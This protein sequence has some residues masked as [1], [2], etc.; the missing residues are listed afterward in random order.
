MLRPV[1]LLGNGLRC[2]PALVDQLCQ[3]NVPVLTTWQGADLVPEDSPVFCGRPGVL[4]Q[5][6]A[7]I[8]QQKSDVLMCIGARLDMEQLGHNPEGFA[9]HA[10]KVVID[11]DDAELRKFPASW[12]R[13]RIDL[14][15]PLDNRYGQ[16]LLPLISG[17]QEWLDWCKAL[18]RRFRY[19]LEGSESANYVDP[20]Y[21]VSKL[22]EAC[23]PDAIIV[24][25]SSGLQSCAMMQAFKVKRGQKML[26]CNTIGAMGMEPMAIGAAVCSG[27]PV[28]MVTGD[29]GFAQNIQEL[30][31]VR[32][33]QLPVKYFVFYN[34]GY[35][36]IANMQ[37]LRFGLRVA[38][39]KSSGLTLPDPERL[40][41][42][43]YMPYRCLERNSDCAQL[44]EILSLPGPVITE[45]RTELEFRYP[46][47]VQSS[48]VN[49]VLIPD[50]MEDM[51]PK[52]DLAAIM[53]E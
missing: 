25:G 50:R 6:A 27:K 33:E 35:G 17:N 28:V 13:F 30:E 5:R 46:N 49:G 7:N 36:S 37:D 21:F 43:F 9:P 8:I 23:P 24:P 3:L 38:S 39:E 44:E 26:L 4:G 19:E 15:N 2:N 48:M 29:G 51:T 31:T 47:K 18:Y 42:A 34:G 52:I 12:H 16:R 22:S 41:H 11:I 10:I 45:V 32:R 20:Y 40:A 53:K 1:M 14:R